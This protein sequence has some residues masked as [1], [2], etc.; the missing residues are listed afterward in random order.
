MT[1]MTRCMLFAMLSVPSLA[2][3]EELKVNLQA[4]APVRDKQCAF[5]VFVNGGWD[6]AK[7]RCAI[8]KEAETNNEMVFIGDSRILVKRDPDEDG[9]AKLYGVKPETDEL[10]F[11][12]NVVAN[13]NCWIGVI[14][15][16]CAPADG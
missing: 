12:G 8:L 3:A 10:R 16:L 13:G 2:R 1:K 14:A 5:S 4:Y 15:K 7:N 11:M 6:A 9:F